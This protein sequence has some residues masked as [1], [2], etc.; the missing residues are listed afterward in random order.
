MEADI[1]AFVFSS[2]CA[3]SGRPERL[4]LDETHPQNPIN[5]YGRTKHIVEQALRDFD[6]CDRMRSVMLRYFNAAGAD[7]EGRIGEW[8]TPETHAIPLAIEASPMTA[9]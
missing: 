9:I 5:P 4:P 6:L 1:R 8:H 3:T 2:T 7:F